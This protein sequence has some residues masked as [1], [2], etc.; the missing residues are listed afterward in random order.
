M[1][2]QEFKTSLEEQQPPP[3]AV[4]LQALWY[5]AKGEWGTAHNLAQDVHTPD[6]SWI[7]AYLHR[8]EGDISNAQYWYHKANRK[9]PKVSLKEEWEDI[10][11]ELLLK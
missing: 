3:V 1:T 9:M 11:N 5:E 10:A 4:L 7:H 8:V 2:L 6:G